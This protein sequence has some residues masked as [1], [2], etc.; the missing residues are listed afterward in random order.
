MIR[1]MKKELPP[2]YQVWIENGKYSDWVFESGSL[3]VAINNL[4]RLR[5]SK[6]SDGFVHKLKKVITTYETLDV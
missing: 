5:E 3:D 1:G 2:V 6:D 4:K